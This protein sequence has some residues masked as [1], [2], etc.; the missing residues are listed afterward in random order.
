[1]TGGGGHQIC[2]SGGN[3]I[4]PIHHL[5]SNAL[6]SRLIGQVLK[7]MLRRNKSIRLGHVVW[8]AKGKTDAHLTKEWEDALGY[9]ASGQRIDR[10]ALKATCEKCITLN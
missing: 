3:C 1:M 9:K 8:F 4:G 5:P 10:V 7:V 6:T 2:L